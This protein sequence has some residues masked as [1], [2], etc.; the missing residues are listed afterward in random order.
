[1]YLATKEMEIKTTRGYHFTPTKM[2]IIK[3]VK[4][5]TNASKNLEKRN[6]KPLLVK[7]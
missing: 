6:A 7:M 2:A 1:M 4:T 3:K 5:I